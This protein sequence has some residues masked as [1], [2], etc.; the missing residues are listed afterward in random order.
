MDLRIELDGRGDLAGQLYRQIVDLVT[1]GMLRSGEALPS[2]REL[3]AQLALSRNTVALAY[4]RLVWEGFVKTRAGVGTFV[5]SLSVG[6]LQSSAVVP[7]NVGP[8]VR[9]VWNQ[10]PD[11]P[12]LSAWTPRFD[13]R[14]GIPDTHSFPFASWRAAVSDQL[15]STAVGTGAYGDPVGDPRLRVAVARHIVVSRSVRCGPEDVLI[16]SGIQQAIDLICRVLLE[17]GDVV[18]VEDPGYGPPRMLF[19]SLG[20]SIVGV[21]V[22]DKG[23]VVDALPDNARLVYVT[24]AHQFPLGVPMSL[25]RRLALLEWAARTGAIII[26]DDYDSEFRF[27]G[28]PLEPLQSLDRHGTVLYVGSFSKVMLP[29]IRLGFL[30]APPALCRALRKAKWVADWHS[31]VP[32]QG[33]L[34]RFIEDGQLARHL[35]RMRRIYAERHH[36]LQTL[37]HGAFDRTLSLVPSLAGLHVSVVSP[38]SSFDDVTMAI[39]AAALGVAVRPL[40]FHSVTLKPKAAG[41]VLGYGA[42]PVD[43]IE[44]ALA[45]LDRCL[46]GSR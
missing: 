4:E 45:L 3:A 32:L 28:R 37:L 19:R 18:A 25:P 22:D 8:R 31:V 44:E 1:S 40:S 15:R 41:L 21:P 6:Q 10:I 30:I 43:D 33:A 12:D 29:T 42:L 46:P 36:R 16:T 27:G 20:L 9:A 14:A 39:K 38:E 26:E 11:P 17:P 35:R 24:P 5:S 23:L 2:S 34:A 7:S 13:F